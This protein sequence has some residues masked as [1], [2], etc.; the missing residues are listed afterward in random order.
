MHS[1]THRIAGAA[2]LAAAAAPTVAQDVL[3]QAKRVVIAPGIS[4]YRITGSVMPCRRMRGETSIR[5]L[6]P[7]STENFCPAK[8]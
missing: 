4:R 7:G 1:F 5:T 2:L 6:S 3:V 8:V